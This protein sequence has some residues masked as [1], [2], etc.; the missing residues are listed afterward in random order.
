[1][2]EKYGVYV[3]CRNKGNIRHVENVENIGNIQNIQNINIFKAEY[4]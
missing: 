2:S 3:V 1:M 4:I